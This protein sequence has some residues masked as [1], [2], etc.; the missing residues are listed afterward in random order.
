MHFG[1]N[2]FASNHFQSDHFNGL[3][4][5]NYHFE[6]R[7]FGSNHWYSNH[8]RT[9]EGISY[10]VG[11]GAGTAASMRGVEIVVNDDA[12]VM[13]I[14]QLLIMSGVLDE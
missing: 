4:A 5:K 11:G 6:S 14:A 3:P 1:S 13:E 10:R 9:G 7:C 12:E 2:H 8:F